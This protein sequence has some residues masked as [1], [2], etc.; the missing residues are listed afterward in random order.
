M[1]PPAEKSK[2]EK[3]L[4]GKRFVFGSKG[5]LR[6]QLTEFVELVTVVDGRFEY[7]TDSKLLVRY[8]SFRWGSGDGRNP[9][10]PGS[11]GYCYVARPVSLNELKAFVDTNRA[12]GN[13]NW[14]YECIAGEVGVLDIARPKDNTWRK[15]R[16]FRSLRTQAR[17]AR[18]GADQLLHL[19]HERMIWRQFRGRC[20]RPDFQIEV[21][22]FGRFAYA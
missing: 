13:I 19:H 12:I 8:K 10:L 4:C 9:V 1:P 17:D 11:N 7:S 20:L 3:T 14:A 22:A 2:S 5:F 16:I 6:D 21:M 15:F 18:L